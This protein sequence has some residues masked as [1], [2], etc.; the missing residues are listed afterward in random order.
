MNKA[1]FSEILSWAFTCNVKLPKKQLVFQQ[2]KVYNH[3]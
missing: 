3:N 2:Q 1:Q